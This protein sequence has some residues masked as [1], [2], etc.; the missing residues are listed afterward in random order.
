M[1]R[2]RLRPKR[3]ITIIVVFALSLFVFAYRVSINELT[4]DTNHHRASASNEDLTVYRLPEKF[5]DPSHLTPID[6]S[7]LIELGT[8]SI[9]AAHRNGI[10]HTGGILFVMDVAGKFLVMKRSSS[11]VT[12]PD[13]WSIV[14]EHSIVGEDANSLPIRALDEELGLVA[15]DV[16]AAIQNLT[17]HP[18]YY[19]RKYGARNGNRIDR[20]VTYLWL[21]T[22]PKS[23]QE[24][25]WRLDH[26]VADKKWISLEVF[27]H[28][29]QADEANDAAFNESNEEK[30]GD[31]GPPNGDFCHR[32]I[33]S[34]LRLG[35]TRLKV[36]L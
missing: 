33:R 15:S 25:N 22:L 9:D 19:I 17:E 24:I 21:V 12:C 26:E 18:L 32:T 20:Q 5:K 27:D 31:D 13:T 10:L 1:E 2:P 30:E 11:V 23:Q 36:M 4:I 8:E 7:I 3:C 34:L 14:G 6:P 35:I 29:L 16:G 28:W